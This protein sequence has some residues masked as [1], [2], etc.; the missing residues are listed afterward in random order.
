MKQ[1]ICPHCGETENFHFNYDY[2]QKHMPVINVLCNECGEFFD[3]SKEKTMAQQTALNWLKDKLKE[4]YD[5]E[6]K[7]PL[8]YTLHLV[9]QAKQME[10]EQRIKDYNAGYTDAQCNHIN[11]AENYANEQEYL[12][13]KL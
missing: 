6:G 1:T 13:S 7:L 12:N 8:A 10:K 11:D 9:E 2:A 4:T 3:D 5:K